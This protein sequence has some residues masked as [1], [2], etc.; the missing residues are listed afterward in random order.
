MA[1][2]RRFG[3]TLVELLVVIAI[4]GVLIALLLPAVQQ[5]REAAR[6]TQCT[7]NL[8]QL[9]LAMHNYH[10][11]TRSLPPGWL[12]VGS[13][14][15]YMG[16]GTYLLPYLEQSALYGQMKDAG[17][18]NK[19]W[20]TI[21]DMTTASATVEVPYGKTVINAFICP[22]DPTDGINSFLGGYGKSNYTGIGGVHYLKSGGANGTFYDNSFTKFRD[23]TDGLSNVSCLAERSTMKKPNWV[24]KVGTLWVGG[25]S[26]GTYYLN[27][28][29][30][31]HEAYYSING[32][33]GS[34]NITSAHPGGVQLLLGDGSGHFVT[35]TIDLDTWKN[36]GSIADGAVLGEF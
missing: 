26:S 9:G 27:N 34:A 23:M 28:A 2:V 31:N 17:A 6:R 5:A 32:K 11:T 1:T 21:A 8:K 24:Q 7:N 33:N 15:N 20:Y 3:F 13:S 19:A 4:I 29:I 36:L 12:N 14:N 25:Y 22:S 18:Y 35:E 10:D 30:V 16:W